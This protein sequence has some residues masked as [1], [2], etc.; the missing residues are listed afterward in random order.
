MNKRE[1]LEAI[2]ELGEDI[3]DLNDLDIDDLRRMY[4]DMT[5][6][7]WAHPNESFEEF[8]EHEILM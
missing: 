5:D 7:S 8:M 1:L 2:H 6:T 3:S 4:E